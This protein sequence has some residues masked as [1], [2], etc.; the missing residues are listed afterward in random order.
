[1]VCSDKNRFRQILINLLS[2]AIKFT[3]QGSVKIKI[4]TNCQESMSRDYLK[5]TVI[6]TGTGIKEEDRANLFSKFSKL[7][8][9]E[10]VNPM[11]TGLGLTISKALCQKLEGDIRV[12]STW[13][14]GSKFTFTIP[15]QKKEIEQHQS[16]I[17]D[18]KQQSSLISYKSTPRRKPLLMKKRKITNFIYSHNLGN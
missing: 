15:I 3:F 13:G 7:E 6:D 8:Y 17:E 12:K 10:K 18:E 1:M 5:V 16:F 9:N 14:K 2:N 4:S 11:G